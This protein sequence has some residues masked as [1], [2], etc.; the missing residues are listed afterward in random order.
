MTLTEALRLRYPHHDYLGVDLHAVVEKLCRDHIAS[1]LADGN[2]EQRLCSQVDTVYWQQLSEV[3][4][5]DQLSRVGI[6]PT[7]SGEGPDFLIEHAGRR[8]WI[9]VITPEPKD[10]PQGGN[11]LP[12]EAILLR[13][14]AAIKEKSERLFGNSDKKIVGYIEK[15]IVATDDAYVIAVNGRLIR[16]REWSDFIGI[17]QFPVVVESVFPVGPI[18]VRLDLETLQRTSIDY[19]HRT[20]IPKPGGHTVPATAFLE[21]HFKPI[22]GIWAV[23]IDES[24]L[25]RL[26]SPMVVVH[27]PG[28]VNPIP[29][30]FLPA[31]SE[32]IA[33][34]QGDSYLLERHD[35]RLRENGS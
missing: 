34:D 16:H 3:L 1:G 14:T 13:W 25:L 10:V 4:L 21:P 8:I 29:E 32:Y 5:A 23:D 17:S 28:A 9:E 15:K 31:H 6:R 18:Q 27:N 24:V 35:G 11:D 20:L 2:A 30:K 19:E 7:H 12:H 26:K 33:I 22:S